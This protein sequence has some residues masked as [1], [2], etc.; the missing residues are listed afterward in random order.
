MKLN[1]GAG[2]LSFPL[3]RDNIPHKE[4]IEPL[5]DCVFE[6]GWVNVDRVLQPGI[7]ERVDLWR[8]PWMRSSN[9]NPFNDNSVSVIWAS[10]ILEHIPHIVGVA[11]GLPGKLAAEYADE[12]AQSDGWF[13]F[14]RE[15]WRVLEPDGLIYIRCPYGLSIPGIS[16]P[17]H[18]RYI[19]PGSF[20]YLKPDPDVP[21]DY[22]H[23][24]HFELAEPF[25]YRVRGRW[26]KSMEGLSA[27]DTTEIIMTYFNVIDELRMV[28]RA[29]KEPV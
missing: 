14:F 18:T 12:V 24:I 7:N 3:D 11:P 4:H 15:C 17:T 16:D 26:V 2:R 21:F 19:T 9:G 5:P 28:L 25:I 6:P 13:V 22:R 27:D 8:F 1:L 10:H 23:G 20:G 29:V